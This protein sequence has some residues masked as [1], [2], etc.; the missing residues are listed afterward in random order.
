MS[1]TFPG[2]VGEHAVEAGQ[3]GLEVRRAAG[4]IGTGRNEA[5]TM[6]RSSAKPRTCPC[7]T[8]WVSPLPGERWPRRPPTENFT[9][10]GVGGH[11]VEQLTRPPPP[12]MCSTSIRRSSQLLEF[13]QRV[14]I[15]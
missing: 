15:G 4:Q 13:V 3:L 1:S 14:A 5:R 9:A 8:A 7:A 12:T 6:A 2:R 11:L 10:Q